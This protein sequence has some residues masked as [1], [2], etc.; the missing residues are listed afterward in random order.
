LCANYRISTQGKVN[1]NGHF[2]DF[3]V[4]ESGCAILRAGEPNAINDHASDEK[5]LL[6]SWDLDLPNTAT[7]AMIDALVYFRAA[8]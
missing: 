3:Q 7:E 4:A 1:K 2:C 8:Q 5:R 6:R